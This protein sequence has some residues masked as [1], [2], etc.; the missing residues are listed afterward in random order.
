MLA[1]TVKSPPDRPRKFGFA[2]RFGKE[3]HAGAELK[4]RA[5]RRRLYPW[6]AF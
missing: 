3:Q 6:A 4:W 2:I 1:S 5:S